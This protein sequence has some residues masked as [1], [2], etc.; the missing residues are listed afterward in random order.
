MVV[1]SPGQSRGSLGARHRRIRLG[2]DQHGDGRRRFASR[3]FPFLKV[4]PLSWVIRFFR[5]PLPYRIGWAK[6]TSRGEMEWWGADL[7]TSA[8]PRGSLEKCPKAIQHGFRTDE[9]NFFGFS[10]IG[11]DCG[12]GCG[13]IDSLLQRAIGTNSSGDN[14]WGDG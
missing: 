12:R 2:Q 8:S 9:P 1:P 4:A 13:G 11:R 5:C 10:L 14:K 3:W 7:P 6:R